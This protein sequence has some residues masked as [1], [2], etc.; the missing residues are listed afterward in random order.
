[1]KINADKTVTN[2]SYAA[3]VSAVDEHCELIKL[4]E[5]ETRCAVLANLYVSEGQ[6]GQV[7]RIKCKNRIGDDSLITNIRETLASHYV[8]KTVGK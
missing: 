3:R 8:G 1:M 4:P 6:P 7:L 5:S 2:N